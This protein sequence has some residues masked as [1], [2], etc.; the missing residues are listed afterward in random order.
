MTANLSTKEDKPWDGPIGQPIKMYRFRIWKNE[1]S[2]EYRMDDDVYA[3]DVPP[4]F[5]EQFNKSG[6][7]FTIFAD[8]GAIDGADG[9]VL[10]ILSDNRDAIAHYVSGFL[11]GRKL[12]EVFATSG[13]F[14]TKE[15][16]NSSE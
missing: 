11:F 14:D 7:V 3:N 12:D 2:D 1:G 5:V 9:P 10:L 6:K 13:G 16:D 4:A 8:S 15:E